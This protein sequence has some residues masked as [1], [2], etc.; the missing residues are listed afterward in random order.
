MIK[1]LGMSDDPEI[2][3][4]KYTGRHDVSEQML[5]KIDKATTSLLQTAEV[6]ATEIIQKYVD[7][8]AFEAATKILL[9]RETISG[10]EFRAVIAEYESPE[11]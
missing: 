10:D 3:S 6:K 4:V 5:A 9:D 7:S 2:G 8:G 11:A 1:E